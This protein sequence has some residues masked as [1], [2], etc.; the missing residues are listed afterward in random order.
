MIC[1]RSIVVAQLK[2]ILKTPQT[3]N[4]T[5]PDRL[6]RKCRFRKMYRVCVHDL[7]MVN[8]L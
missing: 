8:D 4:E 2:K 1:S 6:F 7:F 5:G 3:V